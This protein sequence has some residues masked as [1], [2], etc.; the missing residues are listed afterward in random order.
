MSEIEKLIEK[1]LAELS[2]EQLKN[3]KNQV[4]EELAEFTT[5][6]LMRLYAL[7]QLIKTEQVLGEFPVKTSTIEEMKS[8]KMFR[9]NQ[10]LE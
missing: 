9:E 4:A 6:Q 10:E 1:L 3:L 5:E 8:W 2:A 7:I